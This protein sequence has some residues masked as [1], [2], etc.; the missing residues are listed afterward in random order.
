M[1][2]PSLTTVISGAQQYQSPSLHGLAAAWV[3]FKLKY[4]GHGAHPAAADT[5][6]GSGDR[7][8]RGVTASKEQ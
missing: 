4:S 6:R 8:T 2:L 1:L 5:C 3:R 7:E